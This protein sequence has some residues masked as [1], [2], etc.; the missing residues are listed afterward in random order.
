MGKRQHTGNA[1]GRRGTPTA[2]C[3][4]VDREGSAEEGGG[5]GG[6][7]PCVAVGDRVLVVATIL[8]DP[9]PGKP[10]RAVNDRSP[11]MNN[12]EYSHAGPGNKENDGVVGESFPSSGWRRPGRVP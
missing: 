3:T 5:F 10:P 12:P 7:V 8:K 4:V 9:G 1:Y 6:G 11:T 2:D